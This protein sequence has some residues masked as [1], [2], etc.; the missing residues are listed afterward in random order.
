MGL[1]L[2]LVRFLKALGAA[3]ALVGGELVMVSLM[4]LDF[5]RVLKAG[6]S[7]HLWRPL[8]ASTLLA[9]G[10]RFAGPERFAG[11]LHLTAL[12]LRRQGQVALL[13]IIMLAIAIYFGI[14][15]LL[16][17]VGREEFALLRADKSDPGSGPTA[18]SSESGPK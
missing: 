7:R 18:S 6:L 3:A 17:G 15:Y 1:S 5:R 2:A 10:I 13:V 16:G 9:V 12:S 14:M 4:F 11:W 8:A